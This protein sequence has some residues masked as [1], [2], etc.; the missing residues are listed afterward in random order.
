MRLHTY[1]NFAGNC[2]EALAFYE[3]QL[4]GRVAFRMSYDQMPAPATVP[5][6]MENKILHAR[7]E[8][9]GVELLMS[10]GPVDAA[11]PMGAS[12]LALNVES[13]AEAE[14]LFA[15]LAEGGQVQMAMGETFF[16]HRFGMARDR[17]GV[18]WMVIHERQPE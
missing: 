17:F 10:D 3:Q 13:S 11:N 1:I 18:N 9:A 2:G 8:I 6:G 4:G 16:A 15:L 7:I 12:A 14:R 5:P